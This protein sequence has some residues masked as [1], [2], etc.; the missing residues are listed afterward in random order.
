MPELTNDASQ[1]GK[2]TKSDENVSKS[3][4]FYNINLIK[5]KNKERQKIKWKY[6]IINFSEHVHVR[7]KLYKLTPSFLNCLDAQGKI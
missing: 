7:M 2:I 1:S 3:T 4:S 5:L 6:W